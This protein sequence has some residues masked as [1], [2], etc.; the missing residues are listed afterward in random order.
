M[1]SVEDEVKVHAVIA[2]LEGKPGN[3]YLCSIH[4]VGFT[5]LSS[6]NAC[7]NKKS[8]LMY[9]NTWKYY[10]L[11][12]EEHVGYFRETLGLPEIEGLP[13]IDA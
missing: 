6:G 2:K 3:F 8:K 11:S 10:V 4:G 9:C 7:T 1:I 13:E 12:C 5:D